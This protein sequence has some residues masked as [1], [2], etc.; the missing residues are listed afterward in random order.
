MQTKATE[1][2][3]L[4]NKIRPNL[5]FQNSIKV[6][7]LVKNLLSLCQFNQYIVNICKPP[8]STTVQGIPFLRK[9][10]FRDID[11][12]LHEF[13]IST[14][15]FSILKMNE[16]IFIDATFRIKAAHFYQ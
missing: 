2:G 15:Y 3:E 1:S 13:V 7:S 12:K 16:E 10:W 8:C 6:I 11:S 4:V 14:S 5:H 9:H